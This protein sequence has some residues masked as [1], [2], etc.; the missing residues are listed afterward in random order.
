M[1]LPRVAVTT[2]ASLQALQYMASNSMSAASIISCVSSHSSCVVPICRS[3]GGFFHEYH[4]VIT[5]LMF[6]HLLLLLVVASGI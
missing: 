1:R 6:Q 3:P 2:E 4:P 5:V